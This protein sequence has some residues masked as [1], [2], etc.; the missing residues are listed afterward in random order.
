PFPGPDPPGAKRCS[1]CN[2]TT[3]VW[4]RSPV[5]LEPLCNACGLYLQQRHK[6][7]PKELIDADKEVTDDEIDDVHYTGPICSHCQSRK[8]SVWRRDKSGTRLC[9][10]CGVYARLRGKARPLHLRKN[11]IR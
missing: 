6:P 8:T 5:T 1:H 10:A 4:R 11:K 3:T 7:R 2:V 9:N